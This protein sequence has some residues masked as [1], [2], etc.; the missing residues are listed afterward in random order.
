MGAASPGA[1]AAA[2]ARPHS[3]PAPELPLAALL[4]AAAEAL[5][6]RAWGSVCRV[7]LWP[8]VLLPSLV[9]PAGGR[10]RREAVGGAG[11]AEVAEEEGARSPF[12]P[13]GAVVARAA[14]PAGVAPPLPRPLGLRASQAASCLSYSHRSAGSEST[15]YASWSARNRSCLLYT[16]PSPRD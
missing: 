16:S 1:T 8:G 10:A 2:A 15:R 3:Q 13:G 9:D 11:A 5:A 14:G 4:V 7:V 6:A 12:P